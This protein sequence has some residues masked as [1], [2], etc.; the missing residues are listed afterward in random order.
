M[1]TVDANFAADFKTIIG[2][3]VLFLGVVYQIY[4][5]TKQDNRKAEI[6]RQHWEEFILKEVRK[7]SDEAIK[8]TKERYDQ[9]K[10]ALEELSEEKDEMERQLTL[11]INLKEEENQKLIRKN[12]VLEQ[13]NT[14]YHRIYG[15]LNGR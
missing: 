1:I 15:D 7:N 12:E 4:R 2:A 14:E 8:A 6:D 13:E 5:A 3:I 10:A 9:L 11:Q